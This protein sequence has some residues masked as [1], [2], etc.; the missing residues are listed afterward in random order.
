MVALHPRAEQQQAE[1]ATSEEER[2]AQNRRMDDDWLQNRMT[3]PKHEHG[4]GCVCVTLLVC[5]G[6][7]SDCKAMEEEGPKLCQVIGQR[8]RKSV[9]D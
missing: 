3:V 6:C 5:V 8:N 2:E 9:V 4:G 7:V 1:C